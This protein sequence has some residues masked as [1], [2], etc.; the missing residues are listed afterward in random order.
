[1]KIIFE[2]SV[3]TTEIKSNFL[4]QTFKNFDP[5]DSKCYHQVLTNFAIPHLEASDY[6]SA[7]NQICDWMYGW[8]VSDS[9]QFSSNEDPGQLQRRI[10]RSIDVTS[11]AEITEMKRILETFQTLI[12]FS[13]R[14]VDFFN[15][16]CK[17]NIWVLKENYQEL[18]KDC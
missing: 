12:Y 6:R 16:S 5:S 17:S 14:Q 7:Y 11:E 2:L 18:V 1:M 13:Q 10:P 8:N 15:I 4:E 3:L 9:S